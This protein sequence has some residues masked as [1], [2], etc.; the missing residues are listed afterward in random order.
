MTS[1]LNRNLLME[2]DING[3]KW[4]VDIWYVNK[5]SFMHTGVSFKLIFCLSYKE[6]TQMYNFNILLS[7]VYTLHKKHI[8]DLYSN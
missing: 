5:I 6:V 2:K 8:I 7:V 4:F 1:L 3:R